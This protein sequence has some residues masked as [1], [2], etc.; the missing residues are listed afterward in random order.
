MDRDDTPRELAFCPQTIVAPRGVMVV[1]D[2][3]RDARFA[4][5]PLTDDP[6]IRFYAG[7]AING[8]SGHALGS[9]CVLDSVPRQLPP[10]ELEAL[11]AL[12]R[13]G[14]SQLE[15]RRLLAGQR[16]LVD[17]L[18][19]LDRQRA[20]LS[21]VIA[22]DLRTPLTSIQGY[23][24]LWREENIDPDIAFQTI[25]RGT[26]RLLRLVDDL[27]GSPTHLELAELDLAGLATAAVDQVRPVADAQD[28]SLELDLRPTPFVGDPHRLAQLLDN[29][30]G[31]AVKYA[32]GG[33][34]LVRCRAD[35]RGA[36]LTVEDTGVGIPEDELPRLFDRFYRASTSQGFAAS[37][38]GLSIVKAIV[39]AHEGS[40][41]VE[42]RVGAGTT[43]RVVL[44]A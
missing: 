41:E 8:P 44:P 13:L 37:G 27:V 20:E 16:R 42:S 1:E 18:R 14:T 19:E 3:K 39:E 38:I 17:E 33:R 4:D 30:V 11:E 26:G 12:A 29:L 36:A 10:D 31:N 21:A 28:V 24:Q 40:L 5:N 25:N 32:P 9:L 6:G 43:F 23:A 7:A 15:L 34:V 22:H 35:D 2:A